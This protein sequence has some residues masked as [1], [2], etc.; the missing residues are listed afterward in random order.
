MQLQHTQPDEQKE[1]ELER[2]RLELVSATETARRLFGAAMD[3]EEEAGMA[4]IAGARAEAGKAEPGLELRLRLVQM[5]RELE[6]LEAQL[7]EEKRRSTELESAVEQKDL[8]SA[9]LLA[10]CQRYR[11]IAFGDADA[12]MQRIERQLGF[13]DRQIQQ[14]TKRCSELQFDLEQME[15]KLKKTEGIVDG[16]EEQKEERR[17]RERERRKKVTIRVEEEEEE[18]QKM[19]GEVEQ[20][21]TEY[22]I[23]AMESEEEERDEEEEAAGK[24]QKTAGEEKEATAK[25][26]SRS[27]KP[28]PVD[29]RQLLRE[30]TQANLLHNRISQLIQVWLKFIKIY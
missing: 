28:A 19:Q 7:R 30:A 15:E 9:R 20:Q 14:L 23:E 16:E 13:R 11:K 1:A 22:R 25:E 8:Q 26:A 18:T 17:D 12:E 29:R 27:K 24:E 3:E 2:L 5:D 10:D 6:Q 4:A 21:E